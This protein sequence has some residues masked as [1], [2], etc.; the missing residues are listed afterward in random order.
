MDSETGVKPVLYKHKPRQLSTFAPSEF[1]EEFSN[2]ELCLSYHQSPDI[3]EDN[4][5]GREDE[6][7]VDYES[8]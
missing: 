7:F 5:D 4:L 1:P 8:D 2:T 3:M 6:Y